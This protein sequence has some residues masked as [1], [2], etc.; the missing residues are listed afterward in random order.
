MLINW[1]NA[2][3]VI[4]DAQFG[5]QPNI[6]TAE[7]IFCLSSIIHMSLRNKK[8]RRLYCGFIDFKKAFDTVE[9]FKLWQKLDMYGIRGKFLNVIRSMYD[10]KKSC[11]KTTR[12]LSDVF[13]NSLGLVQGQVLSPNLFSF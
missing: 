12:M 11:I 10:D 9:R 4:T 3:N 1:A 2:Y 6:G 7:A 5:F 13:E 8:K